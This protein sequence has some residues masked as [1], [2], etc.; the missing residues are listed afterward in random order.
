MPALCGRLLPGGACKVTGRGCA[1]PRR[2]RQHP[3]SHPMSLSTQKRV[4][5]PP[6][7]VLQVVTG[8]CPGS[9]CPAAGPNAARQPLPPRPVPPSFLDSQPLSPPAPQPV[10]PRRA[11]CV[12][13]RKWRAIC[14]HQTLFLSPL[15][16]PTG[17]SAQ[18]QPLV[19]N[20][21]ISAR[22][23]PLSPSSRCPPPFH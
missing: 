13:A 11:L 7:W 6:C 2:A 21:L 8:I 12:F 3:A 22:I 18:S 23:G 10:G 14:F 1:E 5:A 15:T 17:S 19:W 4:L 9:R 20:L 16:T